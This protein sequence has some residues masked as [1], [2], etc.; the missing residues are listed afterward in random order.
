MRCSARCSPDD[1]RS[2]GTTSTAKL[3]FVVAVALAVTACATT[4]YSTF[5]GKGDGLIDGKG[6][7]KS[8]RDGMDIWDYGEPPRR[9]R[10]LGII[11]DRSPTVPVG[12]LRGHTL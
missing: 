4:T 1:V 3:I 6:G 11:R 5:E 2:G 10:I 9:F 7:T 12:L 8:V